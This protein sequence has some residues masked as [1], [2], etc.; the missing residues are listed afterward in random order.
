MEVVYMD[1]CGIESGAGQLASSYSGAQAP[2]LGRCNG[3][4]PDLCPPGPEA[5]LEPQAAL[6]DADSGDRSAEQAD[7]RCDGAHRVAPEGSADSC[8]G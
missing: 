5:T 6:V 8:P 1:T 3:T 4:R 2:T 7:S